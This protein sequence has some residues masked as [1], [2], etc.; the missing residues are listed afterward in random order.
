MRA[1]RKD[2]VS[3]SRSNENRPTK[4]PNDVPST[5][6]ESVNRELRALQDYNTPGLKEGKKHEQRRPGKGSAGSE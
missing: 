2:D 1:A 5:P 3:V 4:Q 6:V